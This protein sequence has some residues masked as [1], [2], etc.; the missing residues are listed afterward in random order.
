MADCIAEL[1]IAAGATSFNLKEAGTFF[2]YLTFKHIA[3]TQE[4]T[5]TPHSSPARIDLVSE[6]RYFLALGDEFLKEAVEQLGLGTD[7]H[8]R[9]LDI[10]PGFG[11]AGRY[12]CRECCVHVTQ[13]PVGENAWE[14]SSVA[15]RHI[16]RLK[17]LEEQVHTDE[18]QL[19]QSL[20]LKEED[21]FNYAT[22]FLSL[23]T[24]PVKDRRQCL[25]TFVG[26][27]N[28]GAAV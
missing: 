25:L 22:G 17:G 7:K 26:C 23:S 10:D 1:T 8:K 19:E 14:E 28:L 16:N 13:L 21:R 4:Q 6:G 18:N 24:V 15:I 2:R 3:E 11:Y 12:I 5:D 9:L 20:S 27:L